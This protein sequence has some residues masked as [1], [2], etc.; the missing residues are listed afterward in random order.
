MKRTHFLL[1]RERETKKGRG[2]GFQN[3]SLRS[4]E[5]LRSKFVEPRM[6]VHVLNKGYSWV[7][8]TRDFSEDS[9]N[10]FRKSKVSGLRSVH[11]TF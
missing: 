3:F 8:K 5:F 1:E 9:S 10:E 6:K 4:T 7:P 11:E 2:E